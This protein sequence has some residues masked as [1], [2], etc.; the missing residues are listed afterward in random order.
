MNLRNVEHIHK[1][2]PA[3]LKL[4]VIITRSHEDQTPP[5]SIYKDQKSKESPTLGTNHLLKEIQRIVSVTLD[6]IN[7]LRNCESVDLNLRNSQWFSYLL[8]VK[9]DSKWLTFD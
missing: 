4:G 8:G 1:L 9:G 6:L 3:I 2:P 7:L 5:T